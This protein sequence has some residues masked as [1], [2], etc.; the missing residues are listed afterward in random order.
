[1]L[2]SWLR[3]D[4]SKVASTVTRVVN[5]SP[6]STGWLQEAGPS[7]RPAAQ[8]QACGAVAL[9][10]SRQC[11]LGQKSLFSVDTTFVAGLNPLGCDNS[12]L[13]GD[14]GSFL[15]ASQSFSE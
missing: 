3:S 10:V 8:G 6:R 7:S 13:R 2:L 14:S 4:G 1:M 15:W 12:V 5:E 9:A 11:P